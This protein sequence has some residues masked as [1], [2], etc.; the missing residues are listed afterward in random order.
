MFVI[1][2]IEWMTNAAGH[3]SP[4][5]LA[6]IKVDENWNEIERFN[7]FIRPRDSEFHDWNHVSYTGGTATEFLHA[8]NAHNVL[9][10]FIEWLT[11]D[12]VVLWWY[13]ESDAIFKKLMHLIL[14]SK[15]QNKTITISEYVY[16]FLHGEKYSRGNA[17][18][19]AEARDIDTNPALKHCSINDAS[20]I[21]KLMMTIAYPQAELLNPLERT[22]KELKPSEH[23]LNLPY[24]YDPATNMIHF[25][26]CPILLAREA[27]TQG[28]ETWKT[29]LKK[30]FKPCDCCKEEYKKAFR[31]R[32]MDI[33]ER[34]QYTYVY[35]ADS[36]VFHKYSCGVMLS[37]NS[38]L[39]TR[40][41][42]TV[43]KTGRKPCKLC[44]P[45]PED[46]YTPIPPQLKITRLQKRPKRMVAKDDARAI[47]RQKVAS[48]E[49]YRRLKD[50]TLTKQERDDIFTLTQP[51]FAFWVG[52]GY[53]TFHLRTCSK[54]QEV[55]N[56]RGFATYK[57][58]IRAGYTPC[59]K[60]RP[61][62]KHDIKVSIPINNRVRE[63][64]KVEDMEAMCAEA[65]YEY[66]REGAYLYLE[67]PVGKWRINVSESPVKLDHINLVKTPGTK[68]Y[69]Q[70][71][72]I[73]L[74]FIDSFDY[75]K[76]HDEELERKAVQGKVLVKLVEGKGERNG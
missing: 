5:Q 55:S 3:F 56:L 37:A 44:N 68:N 7:S 73:F 61:T 67:T 72:R 70:Q 26:D 12:D 35:A 9:Q 13:E 71:P 46:T 59:R 40:K 4:T 75:I 25:K 45:S 1:T 31:E 23:S 64:E 17:Y 41:Y 19:I 20:V 52:Q 36:K 50:E 62:A 6:A 49:R 15:F 48:E 21:Q 42:D 14:K 60:C 38:I 22:E 47:L 30:K 34:T 54:L 39:G 33:L 11:E 53:Q 29:P 24:Q 32:N 57:E 43:I 10:S 74:S 51:R 63:D 58:A 69:H 65:G 8:R 27:V 28:F 2:D 76:R 18:R 66:R 16:A